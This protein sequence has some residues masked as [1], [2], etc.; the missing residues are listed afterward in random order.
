[1]DGRILVHALFPLRVGFHES[2]STN[3]TSLIKESCLEYELQMIS[4]RVQENDVSAAVTN[5]KVRY[6]GDELRCVL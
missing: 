1:M 4:T 5:L 3:G 2:S 6:I